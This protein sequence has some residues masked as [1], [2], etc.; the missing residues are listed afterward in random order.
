VVDDVVTSGATV[1]AAR[2]ALGGDLRL[3][4]AATSPGTL[5]GRGEDDHP[6]LG[7]PDARD[8]V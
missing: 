8:D 2:V 7:E 3:G 6:Y 5:V 4:M 1:T